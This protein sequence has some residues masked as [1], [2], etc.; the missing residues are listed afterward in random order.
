[1][2]GTALAIL[3]S[4]L[5][6]SAA[7]PSRA[8]VTD[9]LDL[10]SGKVLAMVGDKVITTLDVAARM[11]DEAIPAGLD[12]KGRKERLNQLAL[13]ALDQLIENELVLQDFKGRKGKIPVEYLQ[14]RIDR[15]VVAQANGDEEKFRDLLHENNM[16]YNDFV[17]QLKQSLAVEMM[18]L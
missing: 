9:D 15:V 6:I 2:R 7:A 14:S 11:R 17:E 18:T 16:T 4:L 3:A 13:E 10:N 12:A 8:A 5:L 1:M